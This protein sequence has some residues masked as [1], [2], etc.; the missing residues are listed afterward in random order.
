MAV[1]SLKRFYRRSKQNIDIMNLP[2]RCD[3]IQRRFIMKERF[4]R[5]S[6]TIYECK[7][8]VIF[9]PKY[10]YGILK[11]DIGEYSRQQVYQLCMQ[12]ED[13][14]VI[15]LNI[16]PDHVHLVVSIPPKYP[17]SEF[18]GYLKGKMALRLFLQYEQLG[19]RYW[20]GH[21]W[22]RGYC[23]S[24]IGLDEERIRKYVQW[25][26]KQEKDIEVAQNRLFE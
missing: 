25:Q 13:V 1:C 10:R 22:G 6:H 11:D 21:I 2:E 8:H 24:T 14:E 5:L 18:M 15:E 7:Y 17:V 12:K 23:V 4:G 26:E 19:R 16:Q 20:G 9:C 3:P